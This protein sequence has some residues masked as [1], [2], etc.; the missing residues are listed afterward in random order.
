MVLAR[1]THGFLLLAFEASHL[2][3][4]PCP[5][6]ARAATT[7]AATHCHA[8]RALAVQAASAACPCAREIAPVPQAAA[9]RLE[10]PGRVLVSVVATA[11]VVA[12]GGFMGDTSM[13]RRPPHPPNLPLPPPILRV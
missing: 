5:C 8:R 4:S 11:P 1:A 10:S 3:I 7:P 6:P 9:P 2:A 12:T 13:L